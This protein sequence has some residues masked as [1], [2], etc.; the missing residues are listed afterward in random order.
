MVQ[1]INLINQTILLTR[2]ISKY[3]IWYMNMVLTFKYFFIQNNQSFLP[4]VV[5]YPFVKCESWSC[6]KFSQDHLSLCFWGFHSLTWRSQLCN[7]PLVIINDVSYVNESLQ[8][9]HSHWVLFNTSLFM[10]PKNCSS[11]NL[12]VNTA[13]P[14]QNTHLKSSRAVGEKMEGETDRQR[15]IESSIQS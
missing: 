9:K 4:W 15:G 10:F 6:A 7:V 2:V 8:P 13:L 1:C 11:N 14:Q 5:V 12:T 3:M